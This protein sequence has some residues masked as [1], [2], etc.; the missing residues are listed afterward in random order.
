[1][2]NIFAKML[3][4]ISGPCLEPFLGCRADLLSDLKD[5]G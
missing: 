3:K 4:K 1:M 5:K 2:Q